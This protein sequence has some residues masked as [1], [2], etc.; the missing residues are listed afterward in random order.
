MKINHALILCAGLGN[1]LNP[2]TL[3]T[4]KPLL[5]FKKK[6]VLEICIETILKLGIKNISINTFYL[7]GEIS[8]F[9]KKKKIFEKY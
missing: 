6:T 8:K 3:N 2:L 5:Y 4:P 9:I 7:G 1:R